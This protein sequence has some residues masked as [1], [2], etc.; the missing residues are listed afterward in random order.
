MTKA[1]VNELAKEVFRHRNLYYNHQPV[2]SDAA[3]DILADELRGFAPD[4]PALTDVG[5]PIDSN[6][7]WQKANHEIPMGSLDKVNSPEEFKSW[8]SGIFKSKNSM[9]V[10]EK[11]DGLSIELIYDNGKL[12][13]AITRGDGLVG[14][15]IV[16]N[17]SKMSGVKETLPSFTG[18]L[19]GEIILKRSKHEK[20][21]S[22]L[23]N[24]RNAASGIA[25]RLDGEGSQYLDILFYQAIGETQDFE[26]EIFQ[27]KFLESLG[28]S[29]PVYEAYIGSSVDEMC[30]GVN[31]RWEEYHNLRASKDY[32]LDGLVIRVN[33]L[34]YQ[35]E[36]G[37]K[38]MRPK[39]ATAFKFRSEFAKTI[40]KNIPC[41]TGN[42]GRITPVGEVE[43]VLLQG[44]NVARASLYNF[45]Y[46][47]ELGIDI[48][49]EVLICKANDVIPRIEEVIKGTGTIFQ[50]PKECPS[51]TGP[52]EMRGEN[53]I[54]ISTDVCPAQ[55]VGRIKNWISS[56]NILEWGDALLERLVDSGK[57]ST[58]AD[59]YKLSIDDLAS[60]ERMGARS[61][62]KCFETLWA[63]NP[64][65]LELLLGSLSIPMVGS[66]TIKFVM[67]SG[68]DSLD[69]FLLISEGS[70][71]KVKGLGPIKSN[72]L[73]V[74]LKR[75]QE[76]I[77]A[78]LAAGIKVKEKIVGPLTGKSFCFTGTM[79]NKRKS[80]EDLVVQNGGQNKSVGRELGYLVIDD[81]NSS[82][83]KASAA[84]KLGTKL[85]SEDD[86]MKMCK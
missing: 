50:P 39:G 65:P 67:D 77:G 80:L 72:S 56:I 73:F 30:D 83:S 74:G 78:L 42:S 6:S 60:M 64:I 75:N 33:D 44:S 23:S 14:E 37:D 85:I 63:H 29:T 12:I 52:T 19:R 54:C 24:P 31:K 38:D 51:C 25:K 86:F 79:K 1:K 41:Q 61:A 28:L 2:I 11:L 35:I 21:F 70:L 8:A 18:S 9:F 55:K 26:S 4:H 84:R 27:F 32:D 48:G 17:V 58:I 62:A 82:T 46:I 16:R 81:V 20:H 66:S 59:L 43:S 68:Y 13:K 15:D 3:F 57:V 10:T 49:A 69:K 22:D 71:H 40:V 53:L 47:R 76:L 7:E 45:S 5:F 34:S 36:L